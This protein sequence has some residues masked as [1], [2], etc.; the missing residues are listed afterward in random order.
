MDPQHW[1]KDEQD[2]NPLLIR[3]GRAAQEAGGVDQADCHRYELSTPAQDH[4]QGPQESKVSSSL[5]EMIFATKNCCSEALTYR[6]TFV[7]I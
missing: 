4:T 2:G 1:G 3:Q 6:K 5:L 7:L